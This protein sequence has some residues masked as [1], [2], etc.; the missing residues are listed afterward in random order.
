MTITNH[1]IHTIHVNTTHIDH[2]QYDWWRMRDSPLKNMKMNF[3]LRLSRLCYWCIMM[4]ID[5]WLMKWFDWCY[6]RSMQPTLFEIGLLIVLKSIFAVFVF[7]NVSLSTRFDELT[8]LFDDWW[9]EIDCS[10]ADWPPAS[11][12]FVYDNSP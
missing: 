9:P 3:R 4:R 7:L 12:I 6:L 2:M 5:N 11:W 1:W 10:H 8:T